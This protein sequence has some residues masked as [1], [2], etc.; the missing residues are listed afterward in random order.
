MAN[1]ES[2]QGAS[3]AQ[4]VLDICLRLRVRV[5]GPKRPGV[6]DLTIKQLIWPDDSKALF[7]E[8]AY[9]GRQQAVIAQTTVADPC[10]QLGGQPVRAQGA[11]RWAADAAS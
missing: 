8:F 10:E 11:Q 4:P 1:I 3:N 6:G 7:L 2:A 9:N 5:D